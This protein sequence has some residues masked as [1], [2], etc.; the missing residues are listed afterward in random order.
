MISRICRFALEHFLRFFRS[1]AIVNPQ[2]GKFR[3]I[4]NLNRES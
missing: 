4:E 2:F 3:R 1:R